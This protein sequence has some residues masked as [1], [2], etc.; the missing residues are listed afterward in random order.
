[1]ASG[2]NQLLKPMFW[3]HYE[4]STQIVRSAYK[5][6]FLVAL[7]FQNVEVVCNQ[8]GI[9]RGPLDVQAAKL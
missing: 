6:E 8:S 4:I 9:S 2:K 7:T 5:L 3:A 1:M